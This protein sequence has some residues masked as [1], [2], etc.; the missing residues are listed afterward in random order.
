M[1][2]GESFFTVNI[3]GYVRSSDFNFN[4]WTDYSV[5]QPAVQFVEGG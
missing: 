4:G 1:S 3:G 2:V 5:A